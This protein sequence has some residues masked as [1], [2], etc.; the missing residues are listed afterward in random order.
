[1]RRVHTLFLL[2]FGTPVALLAGVYFGQLLA[3][4]L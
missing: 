4:A 1:M 3:M 2:S